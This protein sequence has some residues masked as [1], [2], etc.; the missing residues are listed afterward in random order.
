MNNF[1][2]FGSNEE[3]FRPDGLAVKSNQFDVRLPDHQMSVTGL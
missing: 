1:D 2:Y 3:C